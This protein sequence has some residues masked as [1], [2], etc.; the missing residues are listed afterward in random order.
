MYVT[1]VQS[2]EG[3]LNSTGDL[4]LTTTPPIV[5]VQELYQG[6]VVYP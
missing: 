3:V 2:I 4:I 5:N 1:P 6:R